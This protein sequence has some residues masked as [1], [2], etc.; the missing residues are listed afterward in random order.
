M[1]YHYDTYIQNSGNTKQQ[2]SNIPNKK[3]TFM[4]KNYYII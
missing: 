4:L 2:I 1:Y 3:Q